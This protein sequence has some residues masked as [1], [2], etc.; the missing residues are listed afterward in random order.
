VGYLWKIPV[1]RLNF[2]R[3]F[4]S[5]LINNTFCLS[6]SG[7]FFSLLFVTWQLLNTIGHF[8]LFPSAGTVVVFWFVLLDS[9]WSIL[10]EFG[11]LRHDHVWEEYLRK[12]PVL[13]LNSLA[14]QLGQFFVFRLVF[15]TNIP[16]RHDISVQNSTRNYLLFPSAG[17]V[18]VFWF[19]LLDSGWSILNEFGG[20][21]HVRV[22]KWNTF[23]QIPRQREKKLNP[24]LWNTSRCIFR[25]FSYLGLISFIFTTARVFAWGFNFFTL[26][27]I[28]PPNSFGIILLYLYT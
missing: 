3:F 12:I 13:R 16:P 6:F 9:G 21:R 18:V 20:L 24:L 2:P 15:F 11:G 1:L 26:A 19:V 14:F 5:R 7:I 22:K 4:V 27:C 17:T 10:N 28:K 23:S 8:E 25:L